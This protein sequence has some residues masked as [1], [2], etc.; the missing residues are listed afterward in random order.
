MRPIIRVCPRS[1]VGNA[2][3]FTEVGEVLVQVEAAAEPTAEGQVNIDFLVRDTGI[4]IQPDKQEVIFRAFEQED[5]TTTRKYCGI[6]LGLTISSKL[7]SLMGG[8]ITVASEPGR[9]S[10]FTFTAAF[11]KNPRPTEALATHSPVPLRDLRVLVV[12]DNAT[13]RRRDRNAALTCCSMKGQ[14]MYIKLYIKFWKTCVPSVTC[15]SV[16][17]GR[18]ALVLL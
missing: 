10:T 7:A 18:K 14:K 13:N 16:V 15:C 8:K 4:G 5:T 3:K 12:D 6:G 17:Q 9:G 1:V 2:I 11:V